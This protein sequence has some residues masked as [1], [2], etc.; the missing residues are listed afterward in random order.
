MLP[1]PGLQ[2]RQPFSARGAE[3]R[4]QL[5]DGEDGGDQPQAE[6]GHA[7][8]RPGRIDGPG[9]ESL[10]RSPTVLR[11]RHAPSAS[12]PVRIAPVHAMC[13]PCEPYEARTTP[14]GETQVTPTQPDR[15]SLFAV[16]FLLPGFR[17]PSS[18][19]F[20]RR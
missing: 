12:R 5:P 9:S 19:L 14:R 16:F 4:G 20:E 11:I 8:P 1:D 2:V 10:R 7:H 6:A 15:R 18:R 3:D 13:R 17:P